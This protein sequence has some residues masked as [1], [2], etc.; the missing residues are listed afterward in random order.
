[1]DSFYA[2]LTLRGSRKLSRA[3]EKAAKELGARSPEFAFPPAPTF[4][5]LPLGVCEISLS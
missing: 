3:E 2:C 4:P 5:P 1:M